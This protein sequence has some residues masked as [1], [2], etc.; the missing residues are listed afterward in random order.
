M[1]RF[2]ADERLETILFDFLTMAGIAGDQLFERFKLGEE[3]RREGLIRKWDGSTSLKA[4][5][6]A[7][8]LIRTHLVDQ[9]RVGKPGERGI[10]EGVGFITEESCTEERG[11]K[12]GVYSNDA[13]VL[14]DSLDGTTNYVNGD[15]DWC[16]S[17]ALAERTKGGLYMPTIGVIYKPMTDETFWAVK[18]A[19]S[20]REK[21]TRTGKYDPKDLFTSTVTS[22][23]EFRLLVSGF[24]G[25]DPVLQ[26]VL[27][28]KIS[29]C[30]NL[31]YS[32]LIERGSA[33]LKIINMLNITIFLSSKTI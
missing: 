15:N 13:I 29:K 24:H 12:I 4:D 7:D 31:L 23:S 33:A 14:V 20:Y 30:G 9:G 6:D 1:S 3:A 11:Y 28:D 21:L 17:I 32:R 10:Y 2:I 16:I 5:R 19:G 18:G 25:Q 8:L 27:N 26:G 22:L